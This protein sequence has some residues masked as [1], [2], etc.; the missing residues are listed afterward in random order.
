MTEFRLS[1]SPPELHVFHHHFK[2]LLT[3]VANHHL[4]YFAVLFEVK[5]SP[6]FHLPVA[7]TDKG[8]QQLGGANAK[9]LVQP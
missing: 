8:S 6:V 2:R 1:T 4:N 3:P 5:Q 7:A 9:Q